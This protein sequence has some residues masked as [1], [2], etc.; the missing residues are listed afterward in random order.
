ML[1][2][3]TSR[4]S[5][6]LKYP[7]AQSTSIITLMNVDMKNIAN[8]VPRAHNMWISVLQTVVNLYV[9]SGIVKAATVIVVGPVLRKSPVIVVSLFSNAQ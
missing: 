7:E 6:K 8:G 5:L 9:L 2:S 3:Q 1:V 4:K